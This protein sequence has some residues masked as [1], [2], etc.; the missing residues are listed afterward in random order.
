VPVLLAA[1]GVLVVSLDSCIN[2]TLPALAEAFDVGPAGIRWVI[3]CYVLTYALTSLGA[4]VLADRFGPRPV[5]GAGLWLSGAAFVSYLAVGSFGALLA[6]RVAQGLG[7]GLVYG[8]APALVTL[9]L[10]RARRGR[11]LG[12]LALAMGVGLSVGPAVGG[13]IV[14]ALGW[15]W[16]FLFRAPLALLL[17]AAAT[18]LS[19]L[20]RG[21]A[22]WRLPPRAEW[23]R[24]PVLRVCLLAGLANWG[25]FAIFLLAPFYLVGPLALTPTAGGLFFML[26]P[27]GTAAV[28]PLAG[29]LADRAGPRWPVAAGLAAEAAGLLAVSRFAPDTPLPA[30]AAGLA[31]V[32]L[33]L[34]L[35]QVPNLAHAM[36]AFP[37]VRQGVAGGLAFMSRTLGSVA[38]VEAT[39]TVFAALEGRLGFAP[40]FAAALG[41]AGLVCLLAAALALTP[42]GARAT[43]RG[44]S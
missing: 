34:G 14:D 12:R 15:R 2:I 6:A 3:I 29:R 19:R 8:T 26:A 28:A 30:V 37:A 13:V 39:A 4:G 36:A 44:S 22:A 32:G 16:A 27:L 5:F 11:G 41:A 20:G 35:F 42:P 25:Y 43:G 17:A 33:G 9:A 7:G 31:L 38:G 21:D 18:P 10:P 24:W 1:L 40:A 23:L